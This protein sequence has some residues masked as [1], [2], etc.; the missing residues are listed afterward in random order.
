MS[1]SLKFMGLI[2]L[3]LGTGLWVKG[4][5]IY[6]KAELGQFLIDRAWQ[7]GQDSGKT[8]KPWFWAD[9]WPVARLMV[10]SQKISQIV[11]AGD[12]G[13]ALAFGPG[14]TSASAQPG[15]DGV[16]VISGHRDTHFRFLQFLQEDEQI[17][18]Q[19]WEGQHTVYRVSS[20][21]VVDEDVLI[22]ANNNVKS[23]VL[24]TCWPF[25]SSAANSQHRF[26]VHAQAV[27]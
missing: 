9:T 16:V 27:E 14:H 17:I 7:Q 19:N 23:L 24:V 25:D 22:A 5:Y 26:I 11:L 20:M 8:V 2:L 18:L 15:A 12:S 21:Q 10:P 13:Q 1:V 6:L 3:L 4:G